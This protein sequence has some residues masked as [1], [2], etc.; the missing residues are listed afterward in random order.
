MKANKYSVRRD[1]K[2]SKMDTRVILFYLADSTAN[3]KVLEPVQLSHYWLEQ[4]EMSDILTDLISRM[5][6][7]ERC[8]NLRGPEGD[9]ILT[10]N[11]QSGAFQ[12]RLTKLVEA[13]K[14][15]RDTDNT[16][17][18]P[19]Y[20]TVEGNTLKSVPRP[21]VQEPQQLIHT[22]STETS[23]FKWLFSKLED[24]LDD[25]RKRLSEKDEKLANKIGEAFR[26]LSRVVDIS[27]N[28]VTCVVDYCDYM[29]NQMENKSDSNI[30]PKELIA[31]LDDYIN[32]PDCK[33]P[34]Q[35][36]QIFSKYIAE[37]MVSKWSKTVVGRGNILFKVE[38]RVARFEDVEQYLLEFKPCVLNTNTLE[39]EE[40]LVNGYIFSIWDFNINHEF[41]S[42]VIIY[43][44]LG[45]L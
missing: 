15:R 33:K 8:C 34:Q 14:Q 36:L 42:S 18:T 30:L 17:S 2:Y 6:I 28:G 29:L 5:E 20:Y 4:I 10:L 26:I 31:E 45:S 27:S 21:Q 43:S 24:Q 9:I 16:V 44:N 38:S 19:P 22:A 3:I 11:Y 1:G 7:L 40:P 37:E 12:K 13:R 23:D 39:F 25:I 41:P 32:S 35:L